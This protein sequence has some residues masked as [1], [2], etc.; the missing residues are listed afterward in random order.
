M[1]VKLV[2]IILGERDR[3][4]RKLILKEVETQSGR[5]L[6]KDSLYTCFRKRTVKANREINFYL[7]FY[8]YIFPWV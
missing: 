4:L 7:Y 5:K 2:N 1:H 6:K 8:C 3:N